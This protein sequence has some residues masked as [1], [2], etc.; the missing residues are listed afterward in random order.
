MSLETKPRTG[1]IS[2]TLG[3]PFRLGRDFFLFWSAQ[4]LSSIADGIG[5]MALSILL[6]QR[7]GSAVTASLALVIRVLPPLFFGP[8]AALCLDRMSRKYAMVFCDLTRALL[9][10]FVLQ[11]LRGGGLGVFHAYFWMFA[12]GAI[13]SFYLPASQAIVPSLVDADSVPKANAVQ[14]MGRNASMIVGPAITGWLLS[15]VGGPGAM[16]VAAV[17]PAVSAWAVLSIGA[18]VEAPVKPSERHGFTHLR[19]G[20]AFYSKVP[21]AFHLLLIT[22]AVNF[23][24]VPADLGFQFHV[25]KTMGKTEDLLGLAFSVSAVVSIIVGA[26]IATRKSL[27]LGLMLLLG[28]LG[29]GISFALTGLS[30]QPWVLFVAFAL[31]GAT[32]AMI[33]IPI[34]SIYQRITPSD[35]RGRVFAF[36]FA[37]SNLFA[38][39]SS[40]F[41]GLG[42]DR[43][44]SKSMLLILGLAMGS[45]ALFGSLSGRLKKE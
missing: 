12:S 9:C 15:A 33:Q 18:R 40:P 38:P 26:I 14:T 16:V 29:M 37:V 1:G 42:L 30:V 31:F 34:S 4:V 36:R 32:G 7:T 43:Y 3:A 35:I 19:E 6:L 44:G 20:L 24:A 22:L 8:L 39:L 11:S 2:A 5:S 13:G 25:L 21:L 10:L 28:S 45:V 23:C 27:S 17:I 41:V